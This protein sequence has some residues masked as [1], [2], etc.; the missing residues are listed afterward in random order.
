MNF[1]GAI[2][3]ALTVATILFLFWF[4][5][6]VSLNFLCKRISQKIDVL[7]QSINTS[8]CLLNRYGVRAQFA[9]RLSV[10]INN[11]SLHS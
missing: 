8:L 2:V 6:A 4:L 11:Q 3:I 9:Q 1:L 7:S 10:E 5:V